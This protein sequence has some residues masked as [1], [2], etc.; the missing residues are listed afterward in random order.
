M[1]LLTLDILIEFV[2]KYICFALLLF[3]SSL[4]WSQTTLEK[5]SFEAL[6]IF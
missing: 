3:I 1:C 5:Q 6:E 2:K 4:G